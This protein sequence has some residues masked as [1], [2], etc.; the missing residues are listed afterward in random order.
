MCGFHHFVT[1]LVQVTGDKVG[2]KNIT[3]SYYD[4]K[5]GLV[6]SFLRF[7]LFT[8]REGEGGRKRGKETY[9]PPTEDLA[10]NPGMCPDWE[11]N[12]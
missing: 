9:V 10:H 8:F 6:L 2:K 1:A 4:Y 11:L 3:K 7:Y 12:W 5:T